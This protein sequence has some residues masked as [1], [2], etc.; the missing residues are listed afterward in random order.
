MNPPPLY[1]RLL[2]IGNF[3]LL[4]VPSS[5]DLLVADSHKEELF[6]WMQQ[7]KTVELISSFKA[8]A[9]GEEYSSAGMLTGWLINEKWANN[10]FFMWMICPVFVL[11]LINKFW[12]ANVIVFQMPNFWSFWIIFLA[13]FF[14]KK[15]IIAIY[16]ANWSWGAPETWSNRFQQWIVKHPNIIAKLKVLSYG[17]W[18]DG[19]YHVYPYFKPISKKALQKLQNQKS[20]QPNKVFLWVSQ[21]AQNQNWQKVIEFFY[22]WQFQHPHDQLVMLS[23]S[24]TEEMNDVIQLLGIEEKIIVHEGVSLKVLYQYL[25]QSHYLLYLPTTVVWPTLLLEAMLAGCIPIA[26]RVGV[27]PEIIGFGSRGIPVRNAADDIFNQLQKHEEIEVHFTSKSLLI[28]AWAQ[29]L[30]AE[31]FQLLL[32]ELVYD[33]GYIKSADIAIYR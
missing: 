28:S 3:K 8:A 24:N 14:R 9:G 26:T 32:N 25:N 6:G 18:P 23:N 13:V 10:L 30:G 7:A 16:E 27:V 19:A 4:K 15:K 12:K 20:F 1:Q 5:G 17:Q 33:I 29:D 21:P 11:L 31:R 22:K 2:L